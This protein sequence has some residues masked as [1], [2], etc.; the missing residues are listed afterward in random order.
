M[1]CSESA[2]ICCAVYL[3]VHCAHFIALSMSFHYSTVIRKSK[4]IKRDTSRSSLYI[5]ISMNIEQ[6][7]QPYA[8]LFV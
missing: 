6:A 2:I 1:Y 8:Y 4:T 3:F 5:P 7:E